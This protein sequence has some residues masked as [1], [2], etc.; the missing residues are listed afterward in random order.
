MGF[1]N[2]L[3]SVRKISI[4]NFVFASSSSV[5]GGCK[6][7][8][9]KEDQLVDKPISLYAATKKS[10]ELLAYSYS[11]LYKL[12]TIGLRFFTVYGPWG[13]PDMAPY[14]FLQSILSNETIKIYNYGKM[15]RDFT[16]IDD[17]I[18]G[19]FRCCFKPVLDD[20]SSS[21]EQA[22]PFKIFNIGNGNPIQLMDFIQILES[23]LGLN[24]TKEYLPI[25]KGD[26]IETFADTTELQKWINF[27]PK[28]NIEDGLDE[29]I[30]WYKSYHL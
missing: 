26:V 24:A 27:S 2:I 28:T 25:Q 20:K 30:K 9:F 10:N 21:L 23:K 7:L 13:R 18:E 19:L 12:P 11:H 3:E 14:I 22:A 1:G 15:R 4:E 5:Y 17:V 6:D 29:F 8:P 16:Y